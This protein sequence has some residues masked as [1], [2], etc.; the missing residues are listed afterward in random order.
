M[1]SK[2]ETLKRY[3]TVNGRIPP[4]YAQLLRNYDTSDPNSEKLLQY[5]K[6]ENYRAKNSYQNCIAKDSDYYLSMENK[7][8]FNDLKQSL[9]Y[10]TKDVADEYPWHIQKMNENYTKMTSSNLSTDE[11]KACALDLSYYTGKKDNS[12]KSSRNTNV[13]IRGENDFTKVNKWNDGEKFFPI[14]YYL[15]KALANLPFYW[16]N[17]FICVLLS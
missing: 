12:D 10:F 7:Y 1:S 8:C 6:W 9:Q 16:G 14:L 13:V 15:S 17:I 2:D 4:T 11:K 5:C 3:Y